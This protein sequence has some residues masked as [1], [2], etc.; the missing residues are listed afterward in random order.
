MCINICIY[1]LFKN[2]THC[3]SEDQT[4]QSQKLVNKNVSCTGNFLAVQWLGCA[5]SLPRARV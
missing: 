4:D 5:L 3:V 1:N 2:Q